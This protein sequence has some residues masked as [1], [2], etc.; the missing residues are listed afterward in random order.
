MMKEKKNYIVPH[1]KVREL[2]LPSLPLC[3]SLD[4]PGGSIDDF[5]WENNDV[6]AEKPGGFIED[7]E[8]QD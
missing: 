4:R 5:K 6:P 3:G 7:F 1:V 8:W 2:F